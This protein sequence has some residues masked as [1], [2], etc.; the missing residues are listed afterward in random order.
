VGDMPLATQAKILRLLQDGQF[1]RVGGNETLTVNV[2][3]IAATNQ[4]LERMIDAGRFR[5][6]LYYRL[7]GVTLHLPALRERLDDIPELAHYFLFRFNRQL[8]TAVQSISQDALEQLQNY[9][10]PGNIRELQSVIR[11]SLIVSTGPTLLPEFLSI[12]MHSEAPADHETA[13]PITQVSQ[14]NWRLLGDFVERTLR[15]HKTDAYRQSLLRFDR[16]IVSQAMS[17]S[18]G[19]QSR[20]SELLGLSRPT[21]RAKIRAMVSEDLGKESP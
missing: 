14:D 13:Q 6:D 19:Q 10:W 1:Q 7:R 4:D 20:A 5:R 21:L 15:E 2:R 8:G 11:E 9:R 16:L 3:V 18:S 17:L 12:D